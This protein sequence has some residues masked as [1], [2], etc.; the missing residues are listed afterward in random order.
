MRLI[1]PKA[2]DCSQAL[3]SVDF[4]EFIGPSDSDKP[5]I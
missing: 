2:L 1:A 5:L 3:P 4:W